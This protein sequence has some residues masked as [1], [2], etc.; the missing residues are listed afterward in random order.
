[1]A[2]KRSHD[3]VSAHR[4]DIPRCLTVRCPVYN[5]DIVSADT[6]IHYCLMTGAP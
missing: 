1:M 3:Q 6:I 5:V 4:T 2:A